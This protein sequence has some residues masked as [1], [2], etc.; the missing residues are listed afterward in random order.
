IQPVVFRSIIAPP[1]GALASDS[2]TLSV[3]VINDS[4][5]G[6]T[7]IGLSGSGKSTFSG[8]TDTEG[9]AVFSE[10]PEGEYSLLLSG[11]NLVDKDGNSPTAKALTI[12]PE[13]TT[14]ASYTY[15]TAGSAKI[16]FTT[17]TYDNSIKANGVNTLI[18][19]NGNM[20]TPKVVGTVEGSNFTEK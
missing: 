12:L 10:L 14:N 3:T 13:T 8:S 1:N 9:C 5:V 17:K 20:T 6:E 18:A 16:K 19:V 11:T 15:D 2:G 7:G 4:G